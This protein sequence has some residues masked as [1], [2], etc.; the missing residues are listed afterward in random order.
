MTRDRRRASRRSAHSASPR[1]WPKCKPRGLRPVRDRLTGLYD[2]FEYGELTISPATCDRSPNRTAT[3]LGRNS[4]LLSMHRYQS[5]TASC[6]AAQSISIRALLSWIHRDAQLLA[7]LRQASVA[8]T[9]R[10][11]AV[12]WSCRESNPLHGIDGVNNIR[13]PMGRCRRP[14]PRLTSLSGHGFPGRLGRAVE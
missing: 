9:E 2:R 8:T 1:T 13:W 12:S 14:A 10:Y 3:A 6:P 7:L 5:T 4:H 11:T